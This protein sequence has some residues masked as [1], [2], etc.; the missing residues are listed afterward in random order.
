[1]RMQIT[2]KSLI[3]SLGII[4]LLLISF[5][6][7]LLWHLLNSNETATQTNLGETEIQAVDPLEPSEQIQPEP[8]IEEEL[9]IIDKQALLNVL[10][11]FDQRS[12]E[13]SLSVIIYDLED[14]I[15][16]ASLNERKTYFSASLYKL[17]LSFL[18]YED[19]DKNLIDGEEELI[20]HDDYGALDLN[21]CLY[22]M[23]Q[24]SDSFCG[25]GFLAI[26]DY[27]TS[28]ARLKEWGFV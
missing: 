13:D 24:L 27:Q 5:G 17:Y 8:V 11:D 4:T 20:D 10:Q 15:E 2:K 12:I 9:P 22:L 23:V 1:M 7:W 16:L 28:Q 14:Q 26:Y 19:I 21:T 6:S 18:A 3:I 25:E